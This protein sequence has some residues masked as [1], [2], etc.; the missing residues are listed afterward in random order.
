MSTV[1]QPPEGTSAVATPDAGSAEPFADAFQVFKAIADHSFFAKVIADSDGNFRYVNDY[2]ARLCGYTP[3]EMI[4][5]NISLVHTPE[6]LANTHRIMAASGNDAFS[7]PQENW[8]LHRDGRAFP[9]L[10][11]CVR[12][13]AAHGAASYVAM[14]AIDPE[15][16]REAQVAY[17]TLFNEM[18]DGF[19][20]HRIIR[21][22]AG[23]PVDYQF[24]AVN[25]AFERM[26]GLRASDIVGRTVREVLPGIEHSW[27]DT[28]AAVALTGEP[29]RFEQYTASLDKYFEVSVFRPAPGEFATI[30]LDT[31]DRRRAEEALR[32]TAEDLRRTQRA[33][34]LGSWTWDSTTD[35]TSWTET[36]F[37]L[38]GI[39]P[40][41][42]SPTFAE[43]ESIYTR[44][45][46]AVLSRAVA[47]TLQTGVPFELELEI[48]RSDGERRWL[49]AR[50]E[51]VTDAAGRI[52][53]LWGSAQDLTDRKGEEAE[54]LRLE[55][56]LARALRL[57]SV[58]R[59]AGSVAHDFNNMLTVILG[60]TERILAEIA[61]DDPLHADLDE[62]RQAADRSADLTRQLLA[63]TRNQPASPAVLNLNETVAGAVTMLTRLIGEDI[64]LAW[65]PGD[66]LASVR[67]D[68]SQVGQILTNL[69]VNARDAIA[70]V[71]RI[72]IETSHASFDND[73]CARHPDYLP[74]DYV[75]LSV[76]DDGSGMDV[77]TLAHVFEPFFTT[78]E[79]G[80]G[81]GLGLAT[82]YG[83][84]R[85]NDGFASASS[86]PGKGTTFSVYLPRVNAAPEASPAAPG[87][88]AN[89]RGSATI[90]L[91]EDEPAILTLT[92]RWLE[93]QGFVVLPA[94]TP[95]E[96]LRLAADHV[97]AIDLLLTDVIMPEMNG[98][99]LADE[100]RSTRANLKVLFMSGYTSDVI[101]GHGTPGG[102]AHFIAKPFHL[103][104]LAQKVREVL[105]A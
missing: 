71:G 72:V 55:T 37:E 34:H 74:G 99:A 38:F 60:H 93:G 8:Y 100:V 46:Y 59:L 22:A 27:I 10:V 16:L 40:L 87:S 1:E 52:T 47:E 15:P 48:E 45:S 84:V 80:R 4:G 18:L 85:Q 61:P 11:G 24:L 105:G 73:F 12:V 39:D 26:T 9:L 86:E 50:G 44:A 77:T 19:A 57:E 92:K 68:P 54:R 102:D 33:V 13:G 53:G 20:H 49:W 83:I 43:Q 30:F 3:E 29:A 103:R 7:E 98:R 70:G 78:K 28:Y 14:S 95:S 58:G 81:T 97:G 101:T 17:Q 62:I 67:I 90:L 66:N 6:Q 104:D 82:I 89:P 41:A 2:F 76:T 36:M 42:G 79:L 91:V 32:A 88:Q 64:D 5:R 31:T 56:E 65:Q 75:Q 21:D 96:A 25:P 69:C 51:P 35:V 94:S 23:A 63:F